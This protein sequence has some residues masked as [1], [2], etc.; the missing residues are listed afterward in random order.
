MSATNLRLRIA[1]AVAMLWTSLA[2]AQ[3][4]PKGAATRRVIEERSLSIYS[5]QAVGDEPDRRSELERY[6]DPYYFSPAAKAA[7]ISVTPT[8]QTT[9]E[10]GTHLEV[11]VRWTGANEFATVGF[12][13]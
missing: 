7:Q 2:P 4:A 10:K 6:Y 12:V 1:L 5:D 11:A 3:D 9:G 8:A 13:P